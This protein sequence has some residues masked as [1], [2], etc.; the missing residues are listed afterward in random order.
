MTD[1]HPRITEI[2]ADLELAHREL[3]DTVMAIPAEQRDEPADDARWSIAQNVEHL[4]RVEDSIGRLMSKLIA[5]IAASG[6]RETDDSS[7]LDSLDRF[8]IAVPTVRVAA[9]ER[10]HPMEGL[11]TAESLQR[12]AVARGRMID[13]L[14][15]ASGLALTTASAP[16]PYFGELNVYQWG[17]SSAQHTRRHI[18]QI[19]AAAGLDAS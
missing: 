10:S 9:P 18:H 7:L 11:P 16:H 19:R 3:V 14:K 2:V 5:Q 1:L 6:A 13:V 17:I 4:S 8:G 12:F 15:G